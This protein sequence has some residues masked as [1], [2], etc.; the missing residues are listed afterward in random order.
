[1]RD[2]RRQVTRGSWLR[3]AIVAL[4]VVAAQRSLAAPHVEYLASFAAQPTYV[5]SDVAVDTDGSVWAVGTTTNHLLP[6][7][8][9]A[10]DTQFDAGDFDEGFVLKFDP[11]GAMVYASYL[12]GRNVD[13]LA[14]IEIDAD[15]NVYLAG[16][17]ILR[18]LPD[19]GRRLSTDAR[20]ARSRRRVPGQARPHRGAPRRYLFRRQL[21]RPLSRAAC[22]EI[23]ASPSPSARTTPSTSPAAPAAPTCPP[24]RGYQ[25]AYGGNSQDAF[26]ARFDRGLGFA[27]CTY[28]GGGDNEGAYR[29]AVDSVGR[30]LPA[31][32]DHPLLR[33]RRGASRRRPARCSATRR[34]SPTISSP[35]STPPARSAT[36]PSSVRAPATAI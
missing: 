29:V 33:R 28:L 24:P 35:A 21:P 31:R 2:P 25:Q 12:G 27:R 13:D 20:L 10:V 23:P 34:A 18:R 4:A 17:T 6:V 9:N 30:R 16:T 26:L 32:R 14:A 7:T 3:G 36:P 8:A 1:M 11:S 15:G 19:H 5:V 22:A